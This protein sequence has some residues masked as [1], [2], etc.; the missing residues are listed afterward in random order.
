MPLSRPSSN[1][2]ARV[3]ARIS[4]HLGMIKMIVATMSIISFPYEFY[5]QAF[6][7]LKTLTYLQDINGQFKKGQNSE[8]YEKYDQSLGSYNLI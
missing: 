3:H 1:A 4:S 5:I 6:F 2:S 7:N 8:G